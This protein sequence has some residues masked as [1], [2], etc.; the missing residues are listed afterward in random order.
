M[1]ENGFGK[2]SYDQNTQ[3]TSCTHKSINII[4]NK[5]KFGE[6][7]PVAR[8]V[9]NS[10]Q[11]HCSARNFVTGNRRGVELVSSVDDLKG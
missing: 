4:K 5:I 3:V 1:E 8:F 9:G 10:S 2:E 11:F 7:A 6:N